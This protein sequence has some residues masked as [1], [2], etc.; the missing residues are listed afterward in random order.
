MSHIVS[1]VQ[2]NFVS[3]ML[4]HLSH[5][6]SPPNPSANTHSHRQSRPILAHE[7]EEA[8]YDSDDLN[9]GSIV[10]WASKQLPPPPPHG[11]A[12]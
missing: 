5:L 10:E 3:E 9:L 2:H 1:L 8:T 7:L 6:G 4:Q 12:H 11:S